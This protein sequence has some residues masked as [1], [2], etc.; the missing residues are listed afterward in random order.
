MT[1]AEFIKLK[2]WVEES[3]HV[4]EDEQQVMQLSSKV[5]QVFQIILDL[6][7]ANL[8]ELKKLKLKRDRKKA[9]LIKYYKEDHQRALAPKEIEEYILLDDDYYKT[10]GE[11]DWLSM[12]VGYIENTLD[13]I[14]KISF[15]IKN[16]IEIRKFFEGD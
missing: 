14:K 2:K 5:P 9:E 15:N 3:L 4:T 12:V 10:L 7:S 1:E 6:Y 8:Y 11:Y 16:W 13:N